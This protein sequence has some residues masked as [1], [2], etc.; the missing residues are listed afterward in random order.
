MIHFC[1]N[2]YYEWK[3][4]LQFSKLFCKF[5]IRISSLTFS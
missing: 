1:E 2:V 5:E 3:I 4:E